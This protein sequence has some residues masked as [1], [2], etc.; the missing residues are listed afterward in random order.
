[1]KRIVQITA[2]IALLF[3]FAAPVLAESKQDIIA[4]I[5]KKYDAT[6]SFKARFVQKSYLKVMDQTQEA[7]GEVFI[8]KPG[9]MK[10]TYNAP[11]PQVLISNN[12]LL[13]LYLPEE[14]QVTRMKVDSIYS[15]NTPAL[16]LSGEGKLTE[17]FNV[18]KIQREDGNLVVELIPKTEEQGLD[19]LVLLADRNNFQIIGSSVYDKLGNRTQ[20]MFE[21][22]ENNPG[23]SD[24]QFQFQVPPGVE[25]IDLAAQP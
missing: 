24:S 10:W 2:G 23:I 5:Q 21:D 6:Q 14:S 4:A 19:R 9:R 8:K 25:L 13:W 20:M 17:S 16:F 22:I 11:D 18:G 12:K 15:S 1:M 3:F 7:K